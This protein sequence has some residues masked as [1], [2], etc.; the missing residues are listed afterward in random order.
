MKLKKWRH[1]EA[2]KDFSVSL[3]SVAFLV[4]VMGMG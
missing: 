2:Q 1:S 3:S 4:W